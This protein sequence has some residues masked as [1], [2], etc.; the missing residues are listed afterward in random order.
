MREIPHYGQLYNTCGLSSLLMIAIPEKNGGLHRLLDDICKVIG[1]STE[2]NKELNWQLACGYLLLKASFNRT[3]AWHLRKLFD[4]DYYNFKILLNNQLTEKV[5]YHTNKMDFKTVSALNTFFKAKIIKKPALKTYLDDM[6]TNLELKMIALLFGGIYMPNAESTDGTGCYTFDKKKKKDLETLN[7]MIN[8]G[9]M[10]GLFNHW[11]AVKD[12]YKD[13]ENNFV[14]AIND[15]LKST[16]KIKFNDLTSSHR[17]YH[18]KFDQ[19][20]QKQMEEVVRKALKLNLRS[21]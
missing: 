20:L 11:L 14:L 3:L 6:K 10:L 8:D 16:N 19:K 1:A 2:F 5:Q 4:Y 15:P 18:Y 12:L 13:E 7:E 9:L 17:F 21:K